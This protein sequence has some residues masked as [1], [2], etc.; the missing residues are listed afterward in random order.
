MLLFSDN[1]AVARIKLKEA[2]HL[3]E[4]DSCTEQE[5][6][7]KKSRKFRAAKCYDASSNDEDELSEISIMSNLPHVPSKCS[8]TDTKMSFQNVSFKYSVPET[9]DLPNVL[10][11]RSVNV[12]I[13]PAIKI[14]SN[15][16]RKGKSSKKH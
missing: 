13:N 16:E 5:E 12:S 11:K 4:I 2:E 9:L 10:S 14:K 7:R 1:Y 8:I 3:S 6:Y 15:Q